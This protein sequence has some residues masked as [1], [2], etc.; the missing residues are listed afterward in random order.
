[1]V[2]EEGERV[3]AAAK[4]RRVRM[5]EEVCGQKGRLKKETSRESRVN[6]DGDV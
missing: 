5:E 1:M 2:N 3:K 6:M 4:S